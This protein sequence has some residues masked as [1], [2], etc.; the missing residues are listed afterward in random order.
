MCRSCNI[1]DALYQEHEKEKI[2][3]GMKSQ[4][5]KSEAETQPGNVVLTLD[6]QWV[7]ITAKVE[8][9]AAY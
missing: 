3:P 4:N 9:S 2:V 6:R 7:L 8:A 1:D 5:D